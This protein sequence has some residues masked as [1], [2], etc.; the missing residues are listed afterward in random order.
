VPGPGKRLIELDGVRGLAILLVL[1]FHFQAFAGD[2]MARLRFL[3]DWASIGWCGVDLFFALSG[4]LITGILL[5]SADSANL[6]HFYA[7]R[8]LRILPLYYLAITLY[9]VAGAATG[10]SVP[11]P[12][13]IWYWAHLSNW[14]TA[15]A[16]LT[17]PAISHFWSLAIEEQFYFIWPLVV[18]RVSRR[19]LVILG[20]A[21][22]L[23]SLF[24]RNLPVF[25]AVGL[26]YPNVLYRLTPFRID[27]LL[28]GAVAALIYR[29][30]E[31][32]V[33]AKRMIGIC[34]LGSAML[35]A[36]V[37]ALA[38]STSPHTPIM[39]RAGYSVLGLLFSS[40]VLYAAIHSGSA[41]FA[42]RVL[43]LPILRA[44]GKY[45]YC[46]YVIHIAVLTLVSAR[47][48]WGGTRGLIVMGIASIGLLFLLAM[49][50]WYG[51]ER[52]FIAMHARF[53]GYRAQTRSA[54][55]D[56]PHV[57]PTPLPSP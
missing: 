48:S 38:R 15:Y 39:T 49:A 24:I 41:N 34:V 37:V 13:Q 9:F 11:W 44:F 52:H 2:R 32:H 55:A 23:G 1:A 4:F 51:F 3:G 18:W 54:T 47:V 5:D 50:S 53:P 28:T 21:G 57:D 33:W 17:Y 16:P 35:A 20:V 43:R 27:A 36:T 6:L 14:Q 10:R 22:I 7:R 8:A 29:S 46:L 56:Q 19:R 42:V 31:C 25:Q 12:D 30:P 40:A 26:T 45:S